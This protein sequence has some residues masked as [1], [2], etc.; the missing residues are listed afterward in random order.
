MKVLFIGHN[1]HPAGAQL[2][3]LRYLQWLS[4]NRKEIEIHILLMKPGPLMEAYK[5]TGTFYLFPNNKSTR[6]PFLKI[7]IARKQ[8][9]LI[10]RL[11]KENFDTIYSNTILNAS[12]LEKLAVS[13]TP[14]ITHVHEMRFWFDQLSWKEIE[15]LKK[16]TNYF[17]TASRAVSET[18]EEMG[19][20]KS[21][22]T[23][24][25]YVFV[26]DQFRLKKKEQF[27]LKKY[28]DL[29]PD[30]I[31]VG[32]CGSEDFRKGKDWFIPI[33]I[34]VLSKS[35]DLNVHFVWIGGGANDEM[36]FDMRQ[37]EF[38]DRI[39][40][41]DHLSHAHLYF[42]ELSLFLMISREDPFPIVNIEAGIHAIPIIS[43]LNN[44][45]T[46]ELLEDDP[47]LL[48]PYGN[49]PMMSDRIF[50]ILTDSNMLYEKGKFIQAKIKNHYT[51]N[52]VSEIITNKVIEIFYNFKTKEL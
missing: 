52:H 28:L 9:K 36:E 21:E 51:M 39:H 2:L 47:F 8:V 24:P 27:S 16:H 38:E 15:L 13:G 29:P 6:N 30:V 32:A 1:A 43:F 45:G 42:H 3:L 37:S 48:V 40:F 50:S 31:L 14:I 18:L 25:V 34:G 41:I 49:I 10:R 46:Q 20:V 7:Y 17:F 44:G 12:I 26:D 5:R 22:K 19:I 11:L 33:S 35:L 4:V 23:L